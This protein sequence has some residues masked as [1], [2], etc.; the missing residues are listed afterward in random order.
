MEKKV[1]QP[2]NIYKKLADFQQECPPIFRGTK[3]YGYSYADLPQILEV[4]N[5]LL[6][7]NKLGFTQLINGHSLKTILFDTE[8]DQVIESITDIPQGVQLKGMNDFQVM[9]SGI[10]YIRRY[11]LSAI[12]GI[13]TDIDTDA[14]GLQNTKQQQEVYKSKPYPVLS[15]KKLLAGKISKALNIAISELTREAIVDYLGR[16][17]IEIDGEID[18]AKAKE[19]YILLK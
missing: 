15:Y 17:G 13:I 12:L 3:G 9:G 6:K 5:P 4:I 18:E 11:A 10:T 14:Q 2:T 16:E 8:S 7:K 19:I 1:K